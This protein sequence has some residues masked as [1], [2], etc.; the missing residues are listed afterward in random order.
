MAL[1]QTGNIGGQTGG[2]VNY[3][4]HATQTGASGTSRTVQV[5]LK[6]KLSTKPG[7]SPWFGYP[8]QCNLQC[9]GNWSGWKTVKGSEKWYATDAWR[10]YSYTVT[11]NVGT[12][13]S[14]A[15][16]VGFQLDSTGGSNLWDATKSGN[17]TVGSTNTAP[18]MSGS[19]TFVTNDSYADPCTNWIPESS[20]GLKV[21]WSKATDN[22]G[23]T[24]YYELYSSYNN[25]AW[26]KIYDGTALSYIHSFSKENFGVTYQYYVVA[27][28]SAG[29]KSNSIT[30]GILTVN[31]LNPAVLKLK[32]SKFVVKFDT[33]SIPLVYTAANNTYEENNFIYSIYCEEIETYNP[34][35]QW[36]YGTAE[37]F[38]DR[39]TSLTRDQSILFSKLKERVLAGNELQTTITLTMTSMNRFGTVIRKTSV[40]VPVDFR[41]TPNAPT[42]VVIDDANTTIRKQHAATKTYHYIPNGSGK[43]RVKW[44]AATDPMGA[45]IKYKVEMSTSGG[46]YVTIADNLTSLYY[47]YIPPKQNA[48]TTMKFRVST[49][50]EF[51][52]SASTISSAVIFDYWNEPNVIINSVTRAATTATISVTLG[53]STSM[54]GTLPKGTWSGVSSGTFKELTTAQTISLSGLNENTAYKITISHNDNSGFLTTNKSYVI[55]IEPNKPV[56]TINKYG[57]GVGG[58]EA[59]EKADVHVNGNIFS[60]ASGGNQLSNDVYVTTLEHVGGGVFGTRASS[61]TGALKITLP[62][63]WNNVMLKF[64]V[65][66]YNYSLNNS[67]TYS[68]AGYNY[69]DSKSWNNVSAYATGHKTNARANLPVRFGHDG[70]KCCIYIGEVKQVWNYPQIAIKNFM[71]GY[72]GG[73]TYP[74]WIDGWRIDFVTT[75]G[76]ISQTVTNPHVSKLT[77][78]DIGALPT[79]GGI[80]NGTINATNLQVGGNNV[81]HTGRKPVLTDISGAY[82]FQRLLGD[83][84]NLNNYTK[85]GFY[86]QGS[87]AQASNGT[88]YPR[89]Y[90]GVL[91]VHASTDG[92][93]IW[94][95]YHIYGWD[96]S[97]WVRTYY[98]GT[99]N[100]WRASAYAYDL[101]HESYVKPTFQNGWKSY[102]GNYDVRFTKDSM[103]VV[104]LEGLATGG[105][106]GKTIFNL[107]VGYRPKQGFQ[108]AVANNFNGYGQIVIYPGGDVSAYCG[109]SGWMS[110]DGISFLAD[111]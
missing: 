53:V 106:M 4:L 31:T 11:T 98:A 21:S 70:T 79:T 55:N 44:N 104:H 15:I 5:T 80:V 64:D 69:A 48:S 110:L 7:Y 78:A 95:K 92:A 61:H 99:W 94:Q 34:F 105:T 58:T 103:R 50:N 62:Q 33:T 91:E 100:P 25:G 66:I 35:L 90:A 67:C 38:I 49:V 93:M 76:T 86:T 10:S 47:D 111:V 30:S 36:D 14:K 29:A 42:G 40:K 88:N 18:K 96:N 51:G 13:S 77:P 3:E 23:G 8:A 19:L 46:S 102:G 87:N 108:Q 41:T 101:S 17:F 85:T 16:S 97:V 63:S 52:Y 75:L 2:G 71:G 60:R 43:I 32:D 28:D 22:E 56:F 81:Y 84:E 45:S 26:S 6:L 72:G 59:T 54:T 24:I 27:R 74:N 68:I 20:P 83:G 37:I 89:P 82:G 107:P 73:S 65:E 9:N 1:I 39:G 12:T 57:I 109:S